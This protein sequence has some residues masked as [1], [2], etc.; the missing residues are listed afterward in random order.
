MASN[1][2]RV[3]AEVENEITAQGGDYTE[4]NTWEVA[5]TLIS[6]YGDRVSVARMV[7]TEYLHSLCL[8]NMDH[9]PSCP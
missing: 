8:N 3:V 6:Q 2:A 7:P 1:F 5:R 9:E 4:F